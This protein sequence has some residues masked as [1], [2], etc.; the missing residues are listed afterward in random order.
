MVIFL[1]F[2]I[3]M[4]NLIVGQY[5]FRYDLSSTKRFTLS[6]QTENV[7]RGLEG[8][9][10]VMVF[11]QGRG[12][13]YEG[14]LAMLEGYRYLNRRMT[15]GVYDLDTVPALAQRYGIDEY[16]TAVV[17]FGQRHVR[18][19]GVDEQSITN[20]IIRISRKGKKVVYFVKGHGERQMSD[21][22]R[23]GIEKAAESLYAMGYD[24]N[25]L[26]LASVDK[27]PEDADVVVIT[28]PKIEFSEH[29]VAMLNAFFDEG[30]LLLMLD[31]EGN[32]L[33][34]FLEGF[35]IDLLAG[36]VS[37]PVNKMAGSDD[38]V[39]IVSSYPSSPITKGF[40][41][42]T[43]FPTAMGISDEFLFWKYFDYIKLVESSKDSSIRLEGAEPGPADRIEGPLTGGKTNIIRRLGLHLE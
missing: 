9:L 6:P 19:D 31:K 32:H 1:V 15:V 2:L 39:P 17:V 26:N 33:E 27:I 23:N 7:M 4:V 25:E 20:G 38:T 29:E 16:N 28:G 41:L 35:S 24:L 36:T 40:G 11:V 18:V 14:T 34:D 37:D 10:R 22:G 42:T 30:Q 12:T 21:G 13:V 5:Y 8:E 3:V 43:V